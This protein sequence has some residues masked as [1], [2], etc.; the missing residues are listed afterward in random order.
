M[1][2]HPKLR[3]AAAL[4][5]LF[6]LLAALPAFAFWGDAGIIANQVIQIANQVSQIA[7]GISRGYTL[8]SQLDHMTKGKLGEIG[9]L[10][11]TFDELSSARTRLVNATDNFSWGGDFTGDPE[12]LLRAFVR[13]NHS[14]EPPL[15][16]H[17]R[18]VLAEADSV[19]AALFADRLD[20]LPEPDR[21]EDTWQTRRELADRDR[22]F[23]YAALDG[24]ETILELL[25]SASASLQD[26]RLRNSLSDTALEQEQLA[27]QLTAA[28][29]DVAVAQLLAHNSVRD[30]M[31]RQTGELMRRRQLAA[32]VDS[33]P[34]QEALLERVIAAQRSRATLDND[35]LFLTID[36]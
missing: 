9:Q 10:V 30:A 35:L 2:R 20:A 11:Q 33:L 14:S 18:Y 29:I 28:E 34:E 24:A 16:D 5:L 15:T 22:V 4:G 12:R 31:K 25:D 19:S 17:W 6:L 8:E 13:M 7:E 32:W 21:F 36:D 26:T 23:D 27:T 3:R 1:S